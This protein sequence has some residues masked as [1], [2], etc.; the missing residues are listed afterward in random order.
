MAAS[1]QFIFAYS[2]IS[3]RFFL[4]AQWR[5]GY[6]HAIS[7]SFKAERGGP[8]VSLFDVLFT[9]GSRQEFLALTWGGN[10]AALPYRPM[11]EH[12]V[13]HGHTIPEVLPLPDQ[14]RGAALCGTG[15]C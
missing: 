10:D 4:T 2:K 15:S 6:N 8:A 7:I 12:W 3:L 9:I 11:C 5:R 1:V 14:R 13:E